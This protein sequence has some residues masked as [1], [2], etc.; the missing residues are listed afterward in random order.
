MRQ[1][2]NLKYITRFK[3]IA[4]DDFGVQVYVW[5]YY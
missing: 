3:I 4:V 2:K 5:R 1:T